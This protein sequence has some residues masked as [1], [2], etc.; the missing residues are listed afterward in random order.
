MFDDEDAGTVLLED[1]LVDFLVPMLDESA[2]ATRTPRQGQTAVGR[3]C[4]RLDAA[5]RKP[6]SRTSEEPDSPGKGP[7]TALEAKV[8]REQKGVAAVEIVYDDP[9]ASTA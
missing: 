9:S 1:D 5:P 7:T 3:A 8:L 2:M 6:S 4:I